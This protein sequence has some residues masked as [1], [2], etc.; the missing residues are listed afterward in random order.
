MA[1][2]P[3]DTVIRFKVPEHIRR[4]IWDEAEA[5]CV[6]FE[7][8]VYHIILDGLRLR[9]TTRNHILDDEVC[10]VLRQRNSGAK[11]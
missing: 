1:S 8:A 2:A 11:W 9:M 5:S 10:R 4:L 6:N 7:T 3:R